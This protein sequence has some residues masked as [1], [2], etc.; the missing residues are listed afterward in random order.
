MFNMIQ[1][2]LVGKQYG[3]LT[4]TAIGDRILD[5][6]A[7]FVICTCECGVTTTVRNNNLYKAKSCGCLK[8]TA[9]GYYKQYFRGELPEFGSWVAMK[10]RCLNSKHPTYTEYGGRG[11]TI[12]EEWL[13]FENFIT[14]MG[15]RPTPKHSIDRMNNDGNYEP[16]NCRWATPSEQNYNRRPR[17]SS[18]A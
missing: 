3:K 1:S 15:K 8:K 2:T 12:C 6:R 7:F 16:S 9:K 18:K 17:K 4:V 5:S 11:I 14:D 13:D 10:T